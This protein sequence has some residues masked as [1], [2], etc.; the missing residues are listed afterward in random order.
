MTCRWLNLSVIPRYVVRHEVY[1]HLEPRLVRPCKKFLELPHPVLRV[2]G[3]I[4][5]HIVV[6]A[7]GVR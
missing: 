4:W 2:A 1:D 3:Q 6:V 7:Y 5:V